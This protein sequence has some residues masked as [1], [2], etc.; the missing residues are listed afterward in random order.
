MFCC[1]NF[2]GG[3]LVRPPVRLSSSW[4]HAYGSGAVPFLTPPPKPCPFPAGAFPDRW[5]PAGG[6]AEDVVMSTEEEGEEAAAP[7]AKDPGRGEEGG[8]EHK[9]SGV[10]AGGAKAPPMFPGSTD[11]SSLEGSPQE[12][13]GLLFSASNWGSPPCSISF[14]HL[15]LGSPPPCLLNTLCWRASGRDG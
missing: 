3:N 2:L 12:P 10:L 8:A 1:F 4:V 13:K 6:H 7:E 14:F 9:V 15:Y 11:C 5:M